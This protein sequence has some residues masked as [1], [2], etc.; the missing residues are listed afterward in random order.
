MAIDARRAKFLLIRC[1]LSRFSNRENKKKDSYPRINFLLTRSDPSVN[2]AYRIT[3]PTEDLWPQ[4][5]VGSCSISSSSLEVIKS[6]LDIVPAQYPQ[7]RQIDPNPIVDLSFGKRIE[8]SGFVAA[9]YRKWVRLC[10]F[11]D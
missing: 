8:Q 10:A 2:R 4:R 5:N 9:L 6:A 3:M 1:W 11:G 7:A